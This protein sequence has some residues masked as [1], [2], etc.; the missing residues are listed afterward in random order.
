MIILQARTER[1]RSILSEIVITN[2]QSEHLHHC[3]ALQVLCYPTLADDERLKRDHFASH[4]DKFSEGQFVAIHRRSGEVVGSTSGFLTH[5][6]FDHFQHH[7]FYEAIDG[8]WLTHHREDG[9]YY[10]GI[11]MSVHP[12]YRGLGIARMLHDARKM[13]ARKS[14]LRGQVIGGM[15]PGY[16]HY[17]GVM[18][19]HDYVQHVASGLLHDSTLTTQLRNGFRLR[20]MLKNYLHDPPTDG[21]STL[22]EWVNRDHVEPLIVIPRLERVNN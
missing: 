17:R 18:S 12:D 13:L 3:A 9:A 15:I 16:A 5:I 4:L 20:G 2:T 8:G 10:Y 21:W 19:A 22:L 7:T 6:D 11:D 1:K 14:N